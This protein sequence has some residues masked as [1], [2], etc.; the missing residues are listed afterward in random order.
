MLAES[1]AL[2]DVRDVLAFVQ[3][4][5]ES[6]CAATAKRGRIV[7]SEDER[8]DLACEGVAIMYKLAEEFQPHMD[9]YDQP[10]RFSGYAAMFLPRKLGDAW[11]RMHPEHQ[12]RTQPD[13]K[14][15]W[16]YRERAV[17]LDAIVAEDPDRHALMA[18]PASSTQIEGWLR[19]ALWEDADR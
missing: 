19:R 12:L 3:G 1:V 17:S 2:L 4:T 11:H 8:A 14:R 9:G 13:G 18:A 6:W 15:R 10:G 5:L 16:E 7:L